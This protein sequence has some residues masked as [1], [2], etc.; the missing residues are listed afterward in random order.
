MITKK[1]LILAHA[2]GKGLGKENSLET[3]QESLKYKPD[4]IELDIRKSKDGVL[5]CYH[6]FPAI[7]FFL[8]AYF[9]KYLNFSMIKKLLK[10]N[11]LKEIISEIGNQAIIFL[12]I[13]DQRIS[14]NDIDRLCGKCEKEVWLA[15]FSL[16]YLSRLKK[17]LGNKYSYIYNSSFLFFEPGFKA[18]KQAGIDVFKVL[19]WQCSE[20][21]IKRIQEAGMRHEIHALG[22]QKKYKKLVKKY[23]S[24]WLAVDDTSKPD[25]LS[26]SL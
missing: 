7:P 11:A 9:L 17:E 26:M 6:G 13:K 20:K 18:A 19:P 1:P 10:V 8:F 4:I 5:Y 12:D 23:G 15:A 2:G 14:A 3:V 21:R 25:N 22:S 16:K 24:L